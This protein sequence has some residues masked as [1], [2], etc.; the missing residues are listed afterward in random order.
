MSPTAPHKRKHFRV[1]SGVSGSLLSDK[2]GHNSDDAASYEEED[3]GNDTP[4]THSS[5]RR[6]SNDWPLTDRANTPSLSTNKRETHS[7][8]RH[9]DTSATRKRGE[10]RFIEGSMHDRVSN[11]PP[12]AY[13]GDENMGKYVAEEVEDAELGRLKKKNRLHHRTN[14]SISSTVTDNSANSKQSGIFRFGKA[15]ASIFNPMMWGSNSETDDAK[16]AATASKKDDKDALKLAGEKAYAE[17]K[18]SG[19]KG[20]SKG[21]SNH[22]RGGSSGQESY[23]TATN[24]DVYK[25]PKGRM[26]LGSTISLREGLSAFAKTG[27]KDPKTPA[28]TPAKVEPITSIRT[29]FS[30]M[31]KATSFSRPSSRHG[32]DSPAPARNCDVEGQTPDRQHMQKKPSRKDLRKV[33]KLNKHVS[34]LE[35]QIEKAKRELK[36]LTGCD[37]LHP[38]SH[39]P[40]PLSMGNNRK[41]R[42]RPGS[43][44]TLPSESLLQRKEASEISESE[45]SAP[46]P[47]SSKSLTKEKVVEPTDDEEEDMDEPMQPER[48]SKDSIRSNTVI[49]V[50]SS[51]KRKPSAVESDSDFNLRPISDES[52]FYDQD[53]QNMTEITAP[54]RRRQP[55]RQAKIQK[56]VKLDSPGS[57]ERKKQQREKLRALAS[58]PAIIPNRRT[59]SRVPHPISE[60]RHRGS[61]RRKRSS[62]NNRRSNL[63][64]NTNPNPTPSPMLKAKKSTV[65]L[66]SG[67]AN[68]NEKHVTAS[69]TP[70]KPNKRNDENSIRPLHQHHQRKP[71]KAED[72]QSISPTKAQRK[73]RTIDTRYDDD[74]YIPPVPP[75]PPSLRSTALNE[76]RGNRYGMKHKDSTASMGTRTS[77]SIT[78]VPEDSPMKTFSQPVTPRRD[79]GRVVDGKYEWPEDIF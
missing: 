45:P 79:D 16:G 26:G 28:K 42:F 68:N 75:V 46:L 54:S 27:H 67:L 70:V 23:Y 50:P 9:R 43:L 4:S 53:F 62:P 18:K 30:D 8:R 59:S 15:I 56:I 17:L 77:A 57:A 72:E 31:R 51:R 39:K 69:P 78:T 58:D 38:S 5:K 13:I 52:D 1:D 44:A 25:T 20:T 24:D 34:D 65:D 7:S 48:N 37:E 12:S 47:V 63:T 19:F 32:T 36:D 3:S 49:E 66:R 74:D 35:E 60:G 71:K 14:N 33:K 2:P 76:A 11:K 73:K 64:S 6:R 22:S 61:L 55:N 21:E 10:T 29:S 40:P 41:N